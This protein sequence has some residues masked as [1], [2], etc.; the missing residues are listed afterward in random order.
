MENIAMKEIMSFL[1]ENVSGY[2]ATVDN[3]IPR[4]RPFGLILEENR[5]F[6]FC[7]NSLKQV[8]K[9][10]LEV[11]LIEY[12]VTSREMVTI[13]I[14]GKI[15]FCEDIEIKERVLNVYDS[16]KSGYKTAEN[17]IFKVFYI[18]HGT[19]TV[20]DFSGQPPKLIIF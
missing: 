8:Y 20:A 18:E 12:A 16:I 17:P 4:V 7:T 19:V 5:K 2:L 6:Y 14:S 15:A 9:Q 10:L 13:R 1:K 3:G 11:P